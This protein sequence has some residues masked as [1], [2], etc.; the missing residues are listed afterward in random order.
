[1]TYC[2]TTVCAAGCVAAGGLSAAGLRA[3][4]A[5]GIRWRRRPAE[6][7]D[8][9]RSHDAPD[10]ERHQE[11]AGKPPAHELHQAQIPGDEGLIAV[12]AL[13]RELLMF[14]LFRFDKAVFLRK[15]LCFKDFMQDSIGSI[16]R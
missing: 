2:L 12:T 9:L 10:H 5:A 6:C 7:A 16:N 15:I 1:M 13:A 11:A 14:S 8:G 4:T 3:A